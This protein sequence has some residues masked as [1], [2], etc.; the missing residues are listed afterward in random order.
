LGKTFWSEKYGQ[1]TDKFGVGWQLN[2]S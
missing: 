2:L 1:V